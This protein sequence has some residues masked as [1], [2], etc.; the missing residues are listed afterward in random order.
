MCFTISVAYI[1]MICVL[2]GEKSIT[3][4]RTVITGVGKFSN[5][6]DEFQHVISST[7]ACYALE[8]R[9]NKENE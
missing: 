7:T 1:R 9:A 2:I 3:H 5:S 6:S 8:I 4:I